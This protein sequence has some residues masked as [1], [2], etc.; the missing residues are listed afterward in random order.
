MYMDDGVNIKKDGS[1]WT[2]SLPVDNITEY[3]YKGKL[4]KHPLGQLSMWFEIQNNHIIDYEG[5]FWQIA[6]GQIALGDDAC[7]T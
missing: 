1:R 4:R 3:S 5:S 2:V 7:E 6:L